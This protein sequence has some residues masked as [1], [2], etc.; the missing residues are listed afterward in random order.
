VTVLEAQHVVKRYQSGGGTL[1]ALKGVDFAIEPGEFVSIM[2]PSGSGK[3]TL[4]NILGLLD[5]PS[6]GRLLLDGA[7]V[8]D[9]SDRE[10]TRERKRT[11][12]FVFQQ[13]YLLPTLTALENVTVPTLFDRDSDATARARDLLKR[14]GLG[15]RMDH[16]PDQLSGGQKQRVA[17][18]RSLINEPRVLLAD[19]PTGNLDQETGTKIL[20]EFAEI[21]AQDV[22]VIAVTHDPLVNEY[23][24]RTVELVDGVMSK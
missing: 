8:T 9:L 12:G 20:E 13:F 1:T 2:G 7:D 3:S 11:I 24:D 22:A 23:T 19:E 10:R 17:I 6:E 5:V 18:A 4:L 14:V 15:D 21:T 16:R